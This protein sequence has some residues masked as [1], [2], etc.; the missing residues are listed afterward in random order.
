MFGVSD[1]GGAMEMF[2]PIWE[3]GKMAIL[4]EDSFFK[5][6]VSFLTSDST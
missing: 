6:S 3:D 5:K 4:G 2:E 1:A